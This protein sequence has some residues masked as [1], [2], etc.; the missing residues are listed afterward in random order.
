ML[1]DVPCDI[2]TQPFRGNCDE[3]PQKIIAASNRERREFSVCE[4]QFVGTA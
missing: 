3:I 2:V 1:Y 4:K